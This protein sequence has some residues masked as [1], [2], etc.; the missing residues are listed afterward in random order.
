MVKKK[1]KIQNKLGLH[2]RA[3]VKF[4]NLANRFSSSIKIVKDSNEVDGKSVLGILTLAA[5]QGSKIQ[6]KVSGKDE[7]TA[8]QAL[9]DLIDNKFH[10][11]E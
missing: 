5:V 4:V 10:E 6:L 7:E 11:K 8:V 3:A 9:N 2:A 1:V